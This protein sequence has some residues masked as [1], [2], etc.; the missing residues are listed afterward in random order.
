MSFGPA[1]ILGAAGA[2]VAWRRRLSDAWPCLAVLPVVMWFYFYVDIRDHEQVYVGWR[3][4]HL[5][6]MALIPLAGLAFVGAREA[7]GTARRLAMTSLGL[8][9]A[10]ALPTVVIDTFSTG[11]V[12]PNDLGRAWRRT[13][14]ISPDEAEG[15]RWL[16][17][18]TP[19]EAVVQ[20]DMMARGSIMWAYI[21]AFAERRLGAGVPLSMVPLQKYHEAAKRVQWMYGIDAQSAYALADRVGLDYLVVGE[22]E[23]AAHPGLE[24]R[25][26]SIPD[27]LPLAFHNSA[28]SI[29]A[30]RHAAK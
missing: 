25:W 19:P 1:L 22:P 27:L 12:A 6:F 24:A 26:A 29:Y 28:M 14:V 21:P 3:V 17:E 4:G 10:L 16:R 23:R 8:V 20:V 13:E 5:T 2:W 11:D 7:A 18:H 30:V 9:V 15:L